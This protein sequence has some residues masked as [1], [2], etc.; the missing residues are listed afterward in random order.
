MQEKVKKRMALSAIFFLNGLIFST[1]ASRIPSIKALFQLNEAEL[2]TLLLVLSIGSI[3]G[4]PVSGWLVEKHESRKSILLGGLCLGTFILL[5]GYWPTLFIFG[6]GLFLFSFSLRL[7]NIGMNTQGITLQRVYGKN[8]NGSL[9]GSWSLGG[10]AGVGLSTLLVWLDV[11]MTLHFTIVGL[12]GIVSFLFLGQWLLRGDHAPSMQK[13]KFGK[14]DPYILSLGMLVILAGICEGGMF[15]WSGVYFKEVVHVELFTLGYL[16]FMIAMAASRFASDLMIDAIGM[17]RMFIF[18]S[19]T[20]VL[21]FTIAISFP[22]F[23]PVL[24]GFMLVGLG[25]AAFF[26]MIFTLAGK[27]VKYSAGMAISMV[28]TYSTL[29][30]LTGPTLI[31]YIAHVFSLR[32]SFLFFC[33]A[34]L[35]MIPVSRF[36]F[37]KYNL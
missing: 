1:F 3:I 37:R 7:L 11:R 10:I 18:S 9:Q 35:V 17:K 24:I 2:G 15:D 5:L 32:T 16:T 27:S 36:V 30:F 33:L 31:G 13:M 6:C 14:P 21:G 20:M 25:T 29:G 12:L 19:L 22:K 4:I 28:G 23:W 26:P 34:A 8:I